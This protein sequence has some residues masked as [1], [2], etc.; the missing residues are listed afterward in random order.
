MKNC[1]GSVKNK[2]EFFLLISL[3]WFLSSKFLIKFFLRT[4]ILPVYLGTEIFCLLGNPVYDFECHQVLIFESVCERVAW[5]HVWAIVCCYFCVYVVFYGIK[6]MCL[7]G[8][9]I[10]MYNKCRFLFPFST[11][12]GNQVMA[13]IGRLELAKWDNT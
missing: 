3:W 11:E 2:K 1:N 13:K 6:C 8:L 4:P 10:R 12:W 7:G 5:T 9:W